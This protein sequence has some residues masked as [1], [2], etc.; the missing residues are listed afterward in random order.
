MQY[1]NF[2]HNEKVFSAVIDAAPDVVLVVDAEGIICVANVNSEEITGYPRDQLVGQNVDILVPDTLRAAHK[3]L[4]AAYAEKPMVRSMA[5]ENRIRCRRQDGTEFPVEISLSP[6][7]TENGRYTVCILRDV[8]ERRRQEQSLLRQA[9]DLARSNKELE[10]FAY[11]ASH[12]LQEPLRIVAGYCQLLKRRYVGKLDDEADNFINYAVD[13]SIRLQE[14][15]NDL[16]AYSRVSTKAKPFAPVKLSE[17]C[18]QAMANLLI[19][20]S[21][22]GAS[23]T[24]DPLPSVMGDFYQLLQLFQNLIG[25]AVK[26]CSDTS[27]VVSVTSVR[28]GDFWVISVKDNGIGISPKH[29]EKIFTIFQRLNSREKYEGTGIGLAICKKVVLRHGG[30][31]SVAS[32]PGAGATFKFTFPAID[33]V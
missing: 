10:Q 18:E 7:E 14:L 6:L 16:L 27:P 19:S 32:Q 2:A 9:E 28:E 21:E 11:V 15:I 24:V 25:N 5:R 13:G 30:D 4:R 3:N 20:I 33:N 17:V 31:I 1:K 12:D 8:A 29:F 23:I 22:K 26:F